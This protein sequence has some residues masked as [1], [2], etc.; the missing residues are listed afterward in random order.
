M[1]TSFDPT[2]FKDKMRAEWGSAA[3]GWR[4]WHDVVEAEDAGQRHSAKLVELAAIGP[5]DTVLDVAGGY[6]EPSLTAARA[7]VPGGRV[8]CTDISG[9]MLAL[10]EERAAKA[11]LDNV[12]FL[13]SD[14][15][16]LD[17]AAESF[18]AILSR[19][20]L[21]LLP[22]LAGTLRRLY[23]FLKRGRRL[24]A[25]VWGPQPT[26]QFT[27][28]VPIIFAELRLPPP[29]PGQPGIFALAD[30]TKFATLVQEAGFANVK[31]GTVDI[32]FTVGSPRRYTE[33]IRD[34]APG[35]AA[36]ADSQPP[37]V[38]ERVWNKV[39]EAWSQFQD[40]KGRVRTH[41]QANWVVAT[42]LA[43]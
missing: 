9:E 10:G 39:T 42:R 32:V 4:K 1:S 12:V 29:P 43:P 34:V 13:R 33:F 8:V 37:D 35:I 25:T 38:R 22:G 30:L 15:E 36:L 41:N 27:A 16:Q 5:G 20:G 23:S 26:V 2:E 24:A 7:V 6:G 14:A 11:G 40:S 21:M 19:A 3:A 28:P 18:D 31:T 17:F